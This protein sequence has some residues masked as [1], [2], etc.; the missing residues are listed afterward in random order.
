MIGAVAGQSGVCVP[1]GSDVIR[2]GNTVIVFTTPQVRPQ[3]ERMFRKPLMG[4]G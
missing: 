2:S 3:V 4:R 1:S